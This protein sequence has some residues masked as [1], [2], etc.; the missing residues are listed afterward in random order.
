MIRISKRPQFD[1]LA[2][3]VAKHDRIGIRGDG[4]PLRIYST[5]CRYDAESIDRVMALGLEGDF[6]FSVGDQAIRKISNPGYK[7]QG[8]PVSLDLIEKYGSIEQIPLEELGVP[9]VGRG[10]SKELHPLW[11]VAGA[12]GVASGLYALIEMI[13]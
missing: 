7:P 8:L 13:S 10:Q 4:S 6:Q 2:A 11:Y 5:D 3:H 9:Q 1:D 12:V